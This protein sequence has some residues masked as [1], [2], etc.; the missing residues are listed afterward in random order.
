MYVHCPSSGFHTSADSFPLTCPS[1][2]GPLEFTDF[3]HLSRDLIDESL[4]GQWRYWPWLSALLPIEE[5]I[6]L[7][8]G[9][10]PLLDEERQGHRVLWKMDS[11]MPTGSYKDRGVQRD[12]QLVSA[13]RLPHG[14]GRFE[15]QRRCQSGLLWPPRARLQ[16]R[17][18]VPADAPAPKRS[19]IATYGAELIEVEGPR[20]FAGAAAA[21]DQDRKPVMPRTPCIPVSSWGR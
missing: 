9:W 7:G 6:T 21:A 13:S 5:F 3:T 11:H 14:H 19:Q 12:G 10:T 4:P 1:T 17:I 2:G 18:F 16:S 15:R 20:H 8:E